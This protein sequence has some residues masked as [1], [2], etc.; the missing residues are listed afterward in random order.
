MSFFRPSGSNTPPRTPGTY[1]RVPAGDPNY[2]LPP[3]NA[4]RPNVSPSAQ[5]HPPERGYNDAP[6]ALFE[7]R[8][9][10]GDRRSPAPPAY[11][12]PPRSSGGQYVAPELSEL[13]TI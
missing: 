13:T 10:Y 6:T 12:Q 8:S 4:M 7:K 9:G 11:H 3:R 1:D 5:Y 2:S